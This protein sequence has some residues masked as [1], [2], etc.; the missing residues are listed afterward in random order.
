M[1]LSATDCTQK[2]PTPLLVSREPYRASLKKSPTLGARIPRHVPALTSATQ[3][4]LRLIIFLKQ[5]SLGIPPR[6]AFCL[7]SS[8]Q[9]LQPQSSTGCRWPRVLMPGNFHS[10]LMPISTLK[11]TDSPSAHCQPYPAVTHAATGEGLMENL[12]AI[13]R[14]G[15][16]Y[17]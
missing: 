14:G 11:M 3:W 9:D 16:I 12:R 4:G 8:P 1:L 13:S 17:L 15:G 10:F 7:V 5:T 6:A 2:F